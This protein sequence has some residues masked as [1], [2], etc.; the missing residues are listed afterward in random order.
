MTSSNSVEAYLDS[1]NDVQRAAL[2]RLRSQILAVAPDAVECIS[3]GIPTFK[4]HG[5]NLVH[6]GAAAKHCS[7]YPGAGPIEAF[8]DIL[9]GYSTSKGTIRFDPTK[10]LPAALV[11]RIVQWRVAQLLD[12]M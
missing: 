9:S 1:L 6:M 2:E 4:L 11:K 10:P 12:R 3:Y 7:F 5:K 8:A